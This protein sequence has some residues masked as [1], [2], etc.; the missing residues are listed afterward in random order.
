MSFGARS[1]H[2]RLLSIL[3]LTTSLFVAAGCSSAS[4]EEVG[5]TSDELQCAGSCTPGDLSGDSLLTPVTRTRGLRR[6]WSPQTKPLPEHYWTGSQQ[7]LRPDAHEAFVRMVKDAYDNGH[8]DLYCTSGYRSFDTQCNLF[9]SYAANEGCEQANTYSAHAGHSEHQLGTVCDIFAAPSSSGFLEPGTPGDIWLKANA[10]KYGFAN[11]YPHANAS[12]ND[13]YIQE[14]WHYRFIGVAAATE[15]HNRGPI[16]VPV[17]IASLSDRERE[18]LGGGAAPAPNGNGGGETSGCGDFPSNGRCRGTV[19]EW[20]RDNTKKTID[21]A[22]TTNGYTAC[23]P[24][25]SG[26]GF[27][28]VVP[29][30][31]PPPSN[32]PCRGFNDNGTCTGSVLE[33]CDNGTYKRVDCSQKTDGRTACGA[34]PNPALGNNCVVP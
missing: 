16:A 30:A 15:L 3:S 5:S 12:M 28:C 6:D 2:V 11:S 4:S 17:F 33:W 23:G 19:L 1:H 13:G 22:T 29:S 24:D 32:D 27:N 8:V 34:D 31:A 21:C 26:D 20:C 25:P 18:A 7:Y 14:V 9:A 10:Y